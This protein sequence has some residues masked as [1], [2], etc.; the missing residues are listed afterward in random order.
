[1]I[2]YSTS[3]CN[4]YLIEVRIHHKF[5]ESD[6]ESETHFKAMQNFTDCGISIS[7]EDDENVNEIK[8]RHK[9]RNFICSQGK[10]E[11]LKSIVSEL[12]RKFEHLISYEDVNEYDEISIQATLFDEIYDI[13]HMSYSAPKLYNSIKIGNTLKEKF[14]YYFANILNVLDVNETLM[15]NEKDQI[16]LMENLMNNNNNIHLSNFKNIMK[17]QQIYLN[18]ILRDATIFIPPHSNLTIPALICQ[19]FSNNNYNLTLY[20][21]N[22]LTGIYVVPIKMVG[23]SENIIFT[24]VKRPDPYYPH[25]FITIVNLT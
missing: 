25:V 4:L 8:K 1:M 5:V 6:I 19:P 22:N 15:K 7:K 11:N 23:G 2:T 16:M 18:P 14:S 21:K 24:H 13:K 12:I 3:V 9:T 17:E 20:I 10:L